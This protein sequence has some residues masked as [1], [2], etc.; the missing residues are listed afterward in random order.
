M[1][2]QLMKYQYMRLQF[3]I[4]CTIIEWSKDLFI[5]DANAFK[6]LVYAFSVLLAQLPE[7]G[8]VPGLTPGRP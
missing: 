2:G 8:V 4:D 5:V 6:H 3:S 1:I 7:F